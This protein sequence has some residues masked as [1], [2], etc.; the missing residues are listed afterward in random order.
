MRAMHPAAALATV[1]AAVSG[2]VGCP[3]QP[4]YPSTITPIY[5]LTASTLYVNNGSGWTTLTPGA[6]NGNGVVVFGSGS[7]AT[8][9]VSGTTSVRMFNGSSWSTV[10][11]AAVTR[12]TSSAGVYASAGA[13]LSLLNPDG[14]TWTTNGSVTTATDAF[15]F[16]PYTFV[17]LGTASLD[18]FNGTAMNGSTNTPLT[19][20][21][22]NLASVCVDALGDVAVGG[23][24]GL[25][26]LFAGTSSWIS[27]TSANVTDVYADSFGNIYGATAS[28]VFIFNVFNGTTSLTL[29][30][31]V[32]NGI[33]VDGAGTIYAATATG[34]QVSRDSGATWTTV[35]PVPN[36]TAVTITAPLYQF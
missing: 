24:S 8:I 14:T 21:V 1:V 3:V 22:G 10:L 34:V 12:L 25:G 6:G 4:S 23:A 29:S 9:Y 26:V 17:T 36:I 30:G 2:L 16:S 20:G 27:P 11:A 32:V 15:S 5:A 28:G 35:L 7:G 33:C 18:Y 13:G 19:P 31:Q